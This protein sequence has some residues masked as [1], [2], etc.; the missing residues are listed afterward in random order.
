MITQSEPPPRL[1]VHF[2]DESV[3]RHH[4]KYSKM[5]DVF[6]TLLYFNPKICLEKKRIQ[7]FSIIKA[8]AYIIIPI[9]PSVRPIDIMYC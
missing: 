1:H 3:R 8:A 9:M 2:V 4:V 5:P 7:I 6:F